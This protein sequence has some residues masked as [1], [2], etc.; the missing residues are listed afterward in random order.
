[1]TPSASTASVRLT[2]FTPFSLVSELGLASVSW[3]AH[4]VTR[5]LPKSMGGAHSRTQGHKV[6]W[7]QS[8]FSHQHSGVCWSSSTTAPQLHLHCKGNWAG[9]Q[10]TLGLARGL[11]SDQCVTKPEFLSEIHVLS[12]SQK[13]TFI[14]LNFYQGH[15]WQ[16]NATFSRW[17]LTKQFSSRVKKRAWLLIGK[18]AIQKSH[19]TLMLQCDLIKSTA[20][21]ISLAMYYMVSTQTIPSQVNAGSVFVPSLMQPWAPKWIGSKVS[22]Q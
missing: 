15:I 13:V 18:P 3:G 1:M 10:Q 7:Q 11:S 2:K 17:K 21:D 19:H 5:Q 20:V 8:S 9:S 6:G 12:W 16:R 22:D 14:E 4:Q